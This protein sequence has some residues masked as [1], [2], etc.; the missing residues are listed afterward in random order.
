MHI[1]SPTA[2]DCDTKDRT[3]KESLLSGRLLG[4]SDGELL[5]VLSLPQEQQK[6]VFEGMRQLLG[7]ATPLL[8]QTK[9]EG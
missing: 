4:V 3:G 5:A 1:D 7:T 2:I 8:P 9:K 6:Q